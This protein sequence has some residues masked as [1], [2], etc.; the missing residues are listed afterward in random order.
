ME[1]KQEFEIHIK[2][3]FKKYYSDTSSFGIYA[4]DL[5]KDSPNEDKVKDID[6]FNREITLVGSMPELENG[7]LYIATVNLKKHPKFGLQYEA[8]TVYQKPFT[9]RE[10]QVSFIGA[11]LT[12]SQLQKITEAYPTE[13][14]IDLIKEDKFD[15]SLVKGIGEKTY[16][17]IKQKIADNEK[18]QKAI[19]QLTGK[20]S[21]PYNAVKRLSD[22]YGSPDTLLQKINKNPYLLTE[23]DGFGF[24]RV[25]EIA[26]SMG[27]EKTSPNRINSCIEY[28]LNEQANN[29]HCW[30]KKTKA[31]SDAIKLL[32]V[33]IAD[34]QKILGQNTEEKEFVVDE[35]KIYMDKY[36][37]YESEIKR[38]IVR[39]LEA[40]V[41]YTVDKVEDIIKEVE[42][43]QGFEFTEEQRQAIYFAIKYNIVIVNGKAGTGKTSVIKGIVEVLKKVEGL[44]Y[45]T[46]ALSGKASQRIQEST[47]LDSY[48]MHRLLGYN[49][50][51]GWAYDENEPLG[52]D[53]IILDEASM[54]NSQLF[55]YLIRAIKDGAKLIITGDT[56][57]LEPIG[58]GNVLVNLLDSN[59]VPKVEL[60]IVH[61]QAQKSGILSC[62][63]MVREGEKFLSNSD[64]NNKRLG[65]LKDLYVYP[66][67]SNEQVLKTTLHI[68]KKYDGNIMDF[69]V[70]APMKNRGSLSTKNLNAEMQKIFNQDPSNVDKRR[71]IEKKDVALLEDDKV[72]INGNNY[73]KGVFN[74]T[75][76]IIEYI[77]T[78]TKDGEVVIDFDEVGRITFTKEEMNQIDLGYAITIHKSQGS[79]WKF[80]VMAIDY[81]SFV[82]LNRQS[83]YTGMTRAKEALFMIVELKALQHSINTD[84]SSERNT[85]LIDLLTSA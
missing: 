83:T 56:A 53:V 75:M 64:F 47:G 84:K 26:L 10:E 69:Q 70:L 54:V 76:G 58:V 72:I 11:I 2:P 55:F 45:A 9:T 73:D 7:K 20:F 37:H 31:I 8:K 49:P 63:N 67:Q 21:V 71:K 33:K 85:F 27:V 25:D 16:E 82:L 12:Q 29:G 80:V 74:G 50:R 46:C 40:K 35:E 18:Y 17:K 81:A 52:H 1:E 5:Q 24:K 61:R 30:V 41:D 39:L 65:E 68:A 79:Q 60:T 23:V 42:E 13:N 77:D 4:V 6:D 44:E 48:T 15:V 14:I 59:K 28:V 38:H 3:S 66:Y 22:K 57:Q 19:I 43:K 36:F 62:A 32:N 78:A 34:V 51:S